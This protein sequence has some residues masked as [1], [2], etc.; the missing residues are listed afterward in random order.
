VRDN[1]PIIALPSKPPNEALSFYDENIEEEMHLLHLA[2]IDNIMDIAEEIEEL[3]TALLSY[4]KEDRV[5]ES[6]I[7]LRMKDT[8]SNKGWNIRH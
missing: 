1:L 3:E 6:W 4:I 7:L 5:C 8:S 2:H